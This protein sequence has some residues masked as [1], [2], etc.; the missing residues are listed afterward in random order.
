M[1]CQQT[2]VRQSQLDF[3]A[4]LVRAFGVLMYTRTLG[5]KVKVLVTQL[6]P[7]VCD[8]IV[9]SPPG[10]SVRGISQARIQE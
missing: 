8:P 10:S 7:T 9:C 3:P 1:F 5:E 4:G 6:F 2:L